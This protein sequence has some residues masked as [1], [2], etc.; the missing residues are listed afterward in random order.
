MIIPNYEELLRAKQEWERTF[1]AV[2][3]LAIIQRIIRHHG[4]QVW[5]EGAIEKGAIFYFTLNKQA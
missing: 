3:R 1:D 5:V 2:P 4:G